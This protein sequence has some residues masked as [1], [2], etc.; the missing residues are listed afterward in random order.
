M[1]G[2]TDYLRG[3]HLTRKSEYSPL[4][5]ILYVISIQKLRTH[6]NTDANCCSRTG[7]LGVAVEMILGQAVGSSGLVAA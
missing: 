1:H 6:L 5:N 2:W 3:P 7:S 4:M